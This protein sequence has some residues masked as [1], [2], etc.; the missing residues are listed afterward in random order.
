MYNTHMQ[1]PKATITDQI[2]EQLSQ[3]PGLKLS[4]VRAVVQEEVSPGTVLKVSV[5]DEGQTEHPL[6]LKRQ[7]ND[8]AYRLYKQYLEPYHLNSPKEYGY[9][10][11]DGQ[12]FLVMDYIK[13][14]PANWD[15]RNNYLIAVKWLI[16]KDLI[17]CQHLDTIQNLDC[18]GKMD[19]YGVDYWL[20]EF[21]RWYKDSPSNPQAEEVWRSVCANQNRIKEAII[22]LNEV[23]VQTVV[24]GDMQMSN[25]LFGEDE[26]NNELFVID[27]TQPHISSVTKDLASL[28][29]NAPDDVKSELIETYRKQIDFQ[30]FE[31][32]FEKAKM[33]RD[34]GYLCWMVWMIN[35]G[36]K[37]DIAQN[38]LERVAT[39]LVMSLG[40]GK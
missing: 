1:I 37:E 14:I 32:V 24:H 31:K 33:L 6:I 12:R 7:E 15:D 3:I 22:E 28:Y 20:P 27:W 9:I 4:Q 40:E 29:D 26:T 17:T 10:E 19:Y 34:I 13:H 21:E 8:T 30:H 36:Q 35:V 23:G 39:S 18:F 2:T 16:K 25:I 11:L 38:E 5:F